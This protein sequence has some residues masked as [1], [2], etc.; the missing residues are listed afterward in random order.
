MRIYRDPEFIAMKFL[1]LSIMGAEKEIG[2]ITE[3][4]SYIVGAF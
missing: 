3:T 4:E 1:P 2:L